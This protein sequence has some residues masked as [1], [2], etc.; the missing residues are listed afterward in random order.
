MPTNAYTQASKRLKLKNKNLKKDMD[1]ASIKY[2][3]LNNLDIDT[4]NILQANIKKLI[5]NKKKEC[6][7]KNKYSDVEE[8]D[9]EKQNIY[10]AVKQLQKELNLEHVFIPYEKT[11]MGL[12]ECQKHLINIRD[13]LKKQEEYEADKRQIKKIKIEIKKVKVEVKKVEVKEVEPKIIKI[14]IEVKEVKVKEVKVEPQEIFRLDCV[15]FLKKYN[16]WYADMNKI[17]FYNEKIIDLKWA[18]VHHAE[19]M[20]HMEHWEKLHNIYTS[21]Y[22][23]TRDRNSRIYLKIFLDEHR[24]ISRELKLLLKKMEFP[25][26]KESM[27]AKTVRP[28]DLENRFW[29]RMDWQRRYQYSESY[30]EMQEGLRKNREERKRAED[31]INEDIR[32]NKE[33]S[34]RYFE[35]LDP[36]PIY[37]LSP[38][39]VLG[40]RRSF[41][42]Q[43]IKKAYRKLALIHHPD[44]NKDGTDEKFKS[45]NHAYD[46]MKIWGDA[47]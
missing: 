10:N 42:S 13:G 45:I 4:L 28:P 14:K 8:D 19:A 24:N 37:E 25:R 5:K 38:W 16:I 29:N 46:K 26:T 27:I 17:N 47:S 3:T 39:E 34:N 36:N 18:D 35:S 31:K 7:I 21:K 33:K 15:S 2:D 12:L 43:Q 41:S 20:T 23:G 30:K 44:K 6:E 22:N 40:C 9:T 11:K 1:T 32:K